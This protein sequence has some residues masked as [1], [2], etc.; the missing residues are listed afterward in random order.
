MIDLMCTGMIEVFTLEIYLSTTKFFAPILEMIDGRWSSCKMLME[1]GKLTNEIRI[2]FDIV[3]CFSDFF[4][5][6]LE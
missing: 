1:I 5:N 6:W 3:V 2:I 4:E